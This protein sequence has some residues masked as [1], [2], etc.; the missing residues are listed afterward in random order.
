MKHL[1]KGVQMKS[2]A[3]YFSPVPEQIREHCKQVHL[4]CDIMYVN[5]ML[6][7]VSISKH[8]G[9]I[10]CVCVL[11]KKNKTI[12]DALT[13]IIGVYA[14]RGFI[15]STIHG[16]NAFEGLTDWLMID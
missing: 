9:M 14:A 15:V 5:S 12:G 4:N 8:I 7:F 16:N 1:Q 3:D 10:H 11:N 13:K 6:F 2:N